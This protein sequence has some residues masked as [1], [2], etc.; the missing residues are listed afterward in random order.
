M[1]TKF[2]ADSSLTLEMSFSGLARP[3]TGR[4]LRRLSISELHDLKTSY[5]DING[6][7]A[8]HSNEYI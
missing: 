1:S 5:I 2:Q 8:H 6:I 4:G 7:I 3:F